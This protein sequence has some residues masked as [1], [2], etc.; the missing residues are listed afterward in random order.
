MGGLAEVLSS[1]SRTIR[2]PCSV[3]FCSLLAA[4]KNTGLAV[5]TTTVVQGTDNICFGVGALF[6]RTSSCP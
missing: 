3:W 6:M 5:F 1:I 4:E 2:L